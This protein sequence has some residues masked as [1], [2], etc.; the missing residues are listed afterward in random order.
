MQLSELFEPDDLIVDF[1]PADKW[2][3]IRSLVDRVGTP[4]TE[5]AHDEPNDSMKW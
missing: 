1:E 3:A 4:A 2:G 5:R